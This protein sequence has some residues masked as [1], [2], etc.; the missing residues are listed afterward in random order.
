MEK[1]ILSEIQSFFVVLL[2]YKRKIS[3]KQVFE[4]YLKMDLKKFYNINFRFFSYFFPI[5]LFFPRSFPS[6]APS[7]KQTPA[8]KTS[9]VRISPNQKARV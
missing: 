2:Y 1:R 6:L 4:K 7:R 5:I 8:R 3:E 9:A